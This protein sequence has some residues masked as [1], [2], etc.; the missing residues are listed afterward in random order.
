[1]LKTQAS[2]LL[3]IAFAVL[4]DRMTARP[5]TAPS[6]DVTAE[7]VEAPAHPCINFSVDCDQFPGGNG[8][9]ILELYR[10]APPWPLTQQPIA[11]TAYAV[12][13]PSS[14]T[15]CPNVAP[16]YWM[17]WESWDGKHFVDSGKKYYP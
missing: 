4:A 9:V 11:W 2:F 17:R 5:E 10:T 1:M 7:G 15:W 12:C 14:L 16:P 3:L 8:T 6:I 13:P